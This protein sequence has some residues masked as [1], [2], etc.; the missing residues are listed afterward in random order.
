MPRPGFV[1]TRRLGSVQTCCL[2]SV[3]TPRLGPRPTP[4]WGLCRCPAWGL[5]LLATWGLCRPR[6]CKE[7][8]HRC[9]LGAEGAL[10][11]LSSDEAWAPHLKAACSPEAPAPSLTGALRDAASPGL[12]LC[13]SFLKWPSVWHL[14]SNQ[15]FIA[16]VFKGLWLGGRG[17]QASCPLCCYK[18]HGSL[19]APSS[20]KAGLEGRSR[21][22]RERPRP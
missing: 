11:D 13:A 7:R 22:G 4:I 17:A 3:P 9:L 19:T 21:E 16:C 6:T 5:C 20:R 10:G 1:P 18:A 2:R 8:L 14:I 12:S 15:A